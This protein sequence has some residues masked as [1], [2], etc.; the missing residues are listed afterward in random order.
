MSSDHS[1]ARLQTI[2]GTA[3]AAAAAAVGRTQYRRRRRHRGGG[4]GV[5]QAD[6]TPSLIASRPVYCLGYDIRPSTMTND[7]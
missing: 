7:D 4:F 2:P 5:A 6:T 3:A 1:H